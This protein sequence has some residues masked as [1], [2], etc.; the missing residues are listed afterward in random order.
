[1]DCLQIITRVT[2]ISNDEIWTR[3]E[4]VNNNEDSDI[5]MSFHL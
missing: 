5:V 1:M 3:T 2:T 4:D